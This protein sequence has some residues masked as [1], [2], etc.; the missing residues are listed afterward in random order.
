M[1]N[2]VKIGL[3]SFEG[4][5]NVQN[6]HWMSVRIL[7]YPYQEMALIKNTNKKILSTLSQHIFFIQNLI[8]VVIRAVS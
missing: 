3:S 6:G 8:R 1:A 7:F 4:V 5:S 2:R